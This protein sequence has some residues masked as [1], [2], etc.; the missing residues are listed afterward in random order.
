MQ[1]LKSYEALKFKKGQ[2]LCVKKVLFANLVTNVKRQQHPVS[3]QVRPLTETYGD[4]TEVLAVSSSGITKGGSKFS[5]PWIFCRGDHFNDMCHQ[6]PNLNGREKRLSQQGR[7]FICLKSGHIMKDCTSSQIK[8]CCHSG[9]R[10]Y[11]NRCLC[12]LKFSKH[13]T[14]AFFANHE[15]Q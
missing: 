4:L 1:W 7:C 11:H 13:E 15:P 12:P 6:Y 5:L 10:G 3:K 2:I 8:S 9:Q 14:G